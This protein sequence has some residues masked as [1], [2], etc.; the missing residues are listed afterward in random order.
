MLQFLGHNEETEY[1]T[2]S[3]TLTADDD[4]A[5]LPSS[6]EPGALPPISE[7]TEPTTPSSNQTVEV[8][9]KAALATYSGLDYD[10]EERAYLQQV[11]VQ[12]EDDYIEVLGDEPAAIRPQDIDDH[13][14]FL[15]YHPRRS[16]HDI[17]PVEELVLE[18]PGHTWKLLDGI[19]QP[20]PPNHGTVML[21]SSHGGERHVS[22][23][24]E[25]DVLTLAEV[26]EH[27]EDRLGMNN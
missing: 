8:D 7:G 19:T 4:N 15:E 10:P 24:R 27:S 16:P 26:N 5:S 2:R 25:D 11:L 21:M 9:D 12:L 14:S 1:V 6:V 3:H 17:D 18:F 13:M 23:E 22:V 20:P